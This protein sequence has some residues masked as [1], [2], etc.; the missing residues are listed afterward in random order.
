MALPARYAVAPCQHVDRLPR[1][2]DRAVGGG[3]AMAMAAAGA[4]ALYY[5]VAAVAIVVILAS[6][7][8]AGGDSVPVA[9]LVMVPIGLVMGAL[10]T[11]VMVAPLAFVSGV[12]AFRVVPAGRR[13][14]GPLAGLVATL[15]TYLV[16][17]FLLA[18]LFLPMALLGGP[19]PSAVVEAAG[20]VAAVVAVAFV[21]T[22]WAALPLGVLAGTLYERSRT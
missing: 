7:A 4:T 6:V 14:A 3:Y 16:A 2:S 1:G 11:A 12:A 22:S 15:L 8:T 18:G 19:T 20:G 17:G 21:A 13:F 5:L 9:F 10:Q